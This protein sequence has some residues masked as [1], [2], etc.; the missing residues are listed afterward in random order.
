MSEWYL[1]ILPWYLQ[2]LPFVA[3]I[4]ALFCQFLTKHNAF[5]KDFGRIWYFSVLKPKKKLHTVEIFTPIIIPARKNFFLFFC[6]LRAKKGKFRL[7]RWWT[8]RNNKCIV[9][10]YCIVICHILR[11]VGKWRT[12][13]IFKKIIS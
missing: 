8:A 4:A 6:L 2:I 1:Q 12:F 9:I 5:F 10:I 3:K 11:T 7:N 13:L